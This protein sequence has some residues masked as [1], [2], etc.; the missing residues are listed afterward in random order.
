M[1]NEYTPDELKRLHETLYDLLAEIHRVCTILDI[2]YFIQGG[3]AIGAFFEQ[4]ILPWDDDIDIGLTRTNYERFLREAPAVLG[5]QYFLQWPGSEPHTPYYFAKLMRRGTQFIDEVFMPV[6][7]EKGIYVDIFPFDRVP[8]RPWLQR[9]HRTACNFLN[10]CFIGKELW[11][12]KYF[13]KPQVREPHDRNI[14]ACWCNWLVDVFVP[15]RTIYLCLSRLQSMF[16]GGRILQHGAHAPRPHRCSQHRDTPTGA[17]RPPVRM[18]TIGFGDLPASP[19]STTAP[20]H[21]ERRTAEPP[22]SHHFLCR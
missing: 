19:L 18:G 6:P 1:A 10:C 3:T 4:A 21:S 7:M 8:D 2:P 13:R 16:G 12:W 5:E 15:K 9:L 17:V 22:S 11:L 20:L 14:V